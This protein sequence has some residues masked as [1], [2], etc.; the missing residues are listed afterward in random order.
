[1]S[2][3]ADSSS[4]NWLLLTGVRTSDCVWL[5][6]TLLVLVWHTLWCLSVLIPLRVHQHYH[7]LTSTLFTTTTPTAHSAPCES[8]F[9]VWLKIKQHA[10]ERNFCF[11]LCHWCLLPVGYFHASWTCKGAYIH[12]VLFCIYA[13]TPTSSLI[14]LC[15]AGESSLASLICAYHVFFL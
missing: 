2:R 15:K 6:R 12:K 3:T 7:K 4:W 10:H 13:P 14:H 1:M 5:L 11:E 8:N 9:L